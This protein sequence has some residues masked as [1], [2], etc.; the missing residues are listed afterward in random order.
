MIGSAQR[1]QETW[2]IMIT[3]IFL[4]NGDHSS[5]SIAVRHCKSTLCPTSNSEATMTIPTNL[6]PD[7]NP[8]EYDFLKAHH[9]ALEG[10][11]PRRQGRE[12]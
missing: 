1:H 2:Q 4:R 3:V 8:W 10:D 12:R 6:L 5:G 7:L 9:Q 11:P